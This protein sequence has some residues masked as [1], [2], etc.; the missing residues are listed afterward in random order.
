MQKLLKYKFIFTF[1]VTCATTTFQHSSRVELKWFLLHKLYTKHI[2]NQSIESKTW[3][4]ASDFETSSGV[5]RGVSIV[6]KPTPLLNS[7]IRVT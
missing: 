5:V 6:P 1:K 2:Q 4:E 3:T 7:W